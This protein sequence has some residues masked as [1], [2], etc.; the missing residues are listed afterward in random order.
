[1]KNNA[2]M[3]KTNIKKGVGMRRREIN[4]HRDEGR[5]EKVILRSGL[6]MK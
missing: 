6:V 1:M 5:L 3:S 2:N 4:K